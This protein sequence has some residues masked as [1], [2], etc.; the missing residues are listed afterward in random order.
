MKPLSDDQDVI[1]GFAIFGIVATQIM[2]LS[3]VPSII[4]IIRAR[5]TL[6]YPTF[7]FSVSIVASTTSI[8]Y[9]ILSDQIVVGL[10]SMMTVGQCIIYE[11]V[12]CF[13]SKNP[14]AI[15]RELFGLSFLVSGAIAVGP[16]FKCPW[17]ADCS[18]FIT[19][20][21]GLI[22]A[23]VSCVRYSAQSSTF[24]QV[25]RTKNAAS[26]SP[27]MTAGA[28][29]GSL[30]WSVYSLLA[31]DAYYLASGLAGTLS[32]LIQI[33]LLWRFPRVQLSEKISKEN[34][35]ISPAESDSTIAAIKSPVATTVGSPTNTDKRT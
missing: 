22:M 12:H 1:R 27:Y 23:I 21:F 5:S 15:F 25:V 13:Y 8:I 18:S 26:I 6:M 30:A 33:Y 34:T 31:G 14:R 24:I 16:L 4:Q 28:L 29:F 11:S 32:S 17:T 20:W 7:P 19:D 35:Q 3:S 10:S 2:N 9:S